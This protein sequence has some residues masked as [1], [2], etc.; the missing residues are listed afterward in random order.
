MDLGFKIIKCGDCH[1]GIWLQT[2]NEI[3]ED[4]FDESLQTIA[5][6]KRE[7]NGD[8]SRLRFLSVTDGGAPNSTQRRQL[9]SDLLEGKAIAAGISAVLQ[10]P[11]KRGIATAILWL[12]PNFRA[13]LPNQYSEA[14]KH[15]GLEDYS[16]QIFTALT[17]LQGHTEP[18]KTLE[19]MLEART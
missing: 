4:G 1:L 11:I 8:V 6:V 5:R 9:L 13:Y 16:S 17:E 19:L 3:P 18:V 10:N 12:N 7:V 15:L 14:F 2:S